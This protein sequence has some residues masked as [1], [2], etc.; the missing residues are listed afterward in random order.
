VDEALTQ[1]A[2]RQNIAPQIHIWMDDMSK[3]KCLSLTLSTLALSVASPAMADITADELWSV[4]QNQATQFGNSISAEAISTGTGLTL[5][6]ITNSFSIEAVTLTSIIDE[7]TMTNQPDGSVAITVAD[8]LTYRVTGIEGGDAPDAVTLR[9]AIAGF[10]GT[11]SGSA[12]NLTLTSGFDQ[13]A[14]TDISFDGIDPSEVPDMDYTLTLDGYNTTATYDFTDPALTGFTSSASLG[15]FT[16]ALDAFEP[17]G[18]SGAT[19]AQPVPQ[20]P[21]PG[22]QVTEAPAPTSGGGGGGN[23]EAHLDI[24][25]ANLDAT[26]AGTIPRGVVSTTL[27]SLPAGTSVNGEMSYTSANV[28]FMFQDGRDMLDVSASNEGGS[29][30]FGFSNDAISYALAANGVSMSV[31]AADLPF[32]IAATAEST[33][34]TIDIPL[35]RQDQPSPFA[36]AIA[37]RGVSVDESLWAMVDPGRAVPRTPATVVVDLTGMVQLFV[38]IMLLNPEDMTAPPG[39]LRSMTLNEL[40]VSFG[41]ADLTGTG[42][43]TFAPGQMMPMPVGSV[44]LRLTGANGLIQSLSNGGLLPPE[45]AG[46]AR[47]ML[48]MFAIPGASADSFTSSIEFGP[49]GSIT[50]NGVPLQ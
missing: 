38:D 39:E 43:V 8:G 49:G 12:R 14:L 46:M 9:F 24:D 17:A 40:Q 2:A 15:A 20:Q 30:G 32:P 31:A 7:V 1:A 28:A 26:A 13:I 35:S 4:W 36:A 42:D 16:L 18:S 19:P 23:G 27:E 44:D 50:A 21:A 25:L 37:Y 41:G 10:S 6:N 22:K 29:I 3:T 45:Q 5:T 47:G 11:A 34:M 48:G 33:G